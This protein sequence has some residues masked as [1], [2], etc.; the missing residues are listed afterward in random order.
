[1]Y[2]IEG[3]QGVK[4]SELKR[5]VKKHGCRFVKHDKKHEK[6]ANA[7]TGQTTEIPRHDAKEIGKGLAEQILKDLG[8][9]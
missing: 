8:L 9:K 1:M 7:K 3:R 4:V 6:W 2:Q 5:L